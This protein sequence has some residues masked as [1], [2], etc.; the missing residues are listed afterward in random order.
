MKTVLVNGA[1]IDLCAIATSVSRGLRDSQVVGGRT[2]I[3]ID[4]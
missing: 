1:M 3:G 4:S 2:H